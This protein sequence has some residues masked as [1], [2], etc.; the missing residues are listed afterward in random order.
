MRDALKGRAG[1]DALCA[2]ARTIRAFVI[3]HPG[4]YAATIRINAEGPD[5][6]LVAAGARVI[7]SL[8]AVV[9]GYK[10]D[11]IDATHAPRMLRS[12]FHGFTVLEAAGGFPDGYRRRRQLRVAHRLR[13]SRHVELLRVGAERLSA[14]MR[15]GRQERGVHQGGEARQTQLGPQWHDGEHETGQ[16]ERRAP[17]A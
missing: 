17:I 10:I 6:L 12:L 2:A 16:G 4:R 11:P 1:R 9:A 3:E 8:S 14:A 7:E 13:G 5:D 15:A